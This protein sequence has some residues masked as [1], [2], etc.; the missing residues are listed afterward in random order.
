MENTVNA[1]SEIE[2]RVY[3][4]IHFAMELRALIKHE[5]RMM[6]RIADYHNDDLTVK[7]TEMLKRFADDA[8]VVMEISHSGQA[9]TGY[10]HEMLVNVLKDVK[11]HL[12]LNTSYQMLAMKKCL[13]RI[14]RMDNIKAFIKDQVG[15]DSEGQES[16]H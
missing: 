9:L 3:D 10:L 11:Y 4:F 8:P 14:D 5:N 13:E 12:N 7:K 6:L 15:Q 16:C 2:N 1:R